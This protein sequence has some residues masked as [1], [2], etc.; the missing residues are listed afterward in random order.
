M[1]TLKEIEQQLIDENWYQGEGPYQEGQKCALT[2]H[3]VK[4]VDGLIHFKYC[5]PS[6]MDSF[7]NTGSAVFVLTAFQAKSLNEYGQFD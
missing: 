3:A 4:Y 1:K 5:V 7:T 2:V 6:P